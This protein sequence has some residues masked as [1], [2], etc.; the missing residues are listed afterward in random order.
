[1]I[2]IRRKR[3]VGRPKDILAPPEEPAPEREVI[4]YIT[5]T[6][7]HHGADILELTVKTLK[8]GDGFICTKKTF[9]VIETR[10]NEVFRSQRPKIF[11][12]KEW[13]GVQHIRRVV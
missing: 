9:D 2:F 1:M 10:M 12:S 8:H 11:K 13:G 3:F 5:H 6:T 4:R 7:L